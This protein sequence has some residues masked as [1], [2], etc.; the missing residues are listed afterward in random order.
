MSTNETDI[1]PDS[2]IDIKMFKVFGSK[3]ITITITGFWNCAI[4]FSNFTR[5]I[6]I[7]ITPICY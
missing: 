4:A 7:T 5:H 1:S 6:A 2:G 3:A